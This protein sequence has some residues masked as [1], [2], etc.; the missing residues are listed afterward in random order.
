MTSTSAPA[1]DGWTPSDVQRT[2][3]AYRR[4]RS[5]RSGWIA[6][7]STV[8]L[9]VV[10]ATLVVNTQ[11]WPRFKESFL[12]VSYGKE[13]FADI[14]IGL[15]LNIRLMVVCEFFILILALLLAL[16]RSLRG[17][18]FFPVRAAATVYTDVF[19]GLPLLLVLYLL[20]FGVPALRINGLP[21]NSLIWGA[22]GLILTYTAYNAE[23]LRS[24]MESVHPSQRAASRSLGLSHAKTMRYVVIPQAFR[25]VMPPLL[26]DLVSLQKDTALIAALGTPYYD[27]V[28]QAQIDTTT[29]YNYTPYVIAGLLF[30]ALTI[31]MTRFTDW[32][33]RRQGWTT[34]GGI[35]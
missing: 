13:V 32:I 3:L 25:R 8:V 21:S 30:L 12:N 4:S 14:A 10:V 31:P 27:A 1:V 20:G 22:I 17:P 9:V 34:A 29:S 23:V 18:V 16:A 28:L 15:W 6:G 35:V 7:I 26:N 2:R 11:G 24:G 19:R 5:R 33:A